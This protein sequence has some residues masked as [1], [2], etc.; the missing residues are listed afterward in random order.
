MMSEIEK[1]EMKNDVSVALKIL[2]N[3]KMKAEASK[4]M[5]LVLK[6]RFFDD[7]TRERRKYNS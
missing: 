2:E 3:T 1:F 6:L 5:A 7:M 4:R